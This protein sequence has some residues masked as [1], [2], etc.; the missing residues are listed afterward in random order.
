M[1]KMETVDEFIYLGLKLQNN[2]DESNEI[3]RRI[4][5]AQKLKCLEKLQILDFMRKV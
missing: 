1:I 4:G 2:R 3:S 5:L